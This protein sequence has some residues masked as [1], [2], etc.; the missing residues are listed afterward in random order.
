MATGHSRRHTASDI[1]SELRH[2]DSGHGQLRPSRRGLGPHAAGAGTR[3]RRARHRGGPFHHRGRF[4]RGPRLRP[5]TA[6]R[7]SRPCSTPRPCTSRMSPPTTARISSTPTSPAR[8]TCSRKRSRPACAR[9]SSPARPASSAR[10]WCRRLA[11]PPLGSPKTSAGPEEHLRRHQGGGRGSL[12][13]VPS[14]PAASPASCSGRRAS[15][16]RRTTTG[17]REAYADDNVKANEYL[18]RRVDIEDVVGAHLLAARLA[19]SLGFRRYIISATTPFSPA[20]L[21]ELTPRCGTRL[22]RCVPEYEA[23]YAA[24]AGRCCRP[25]TASMSTRGRGANSAGG[26]ATIS[27]L[28]ERLR[29]QGCQKPARPPRRRQGLSREDISPKVLILW[30]ER[31]FADDDIRVPNVPRRGSADEELERSEVWQDA[32]W[33]LTVSLSSEVAG[34]AYLEPKRHIRYITE[35]DGPEAAS[36]GPALGAQHKCPQG[37]CGRGGGLCLHLR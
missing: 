11:R 17:V 35:L 29:R 34:F 24:A 15:S 31:S 14:Q 6:W 21:A 28:I 37:R 9:S 12:P 23:E 25:S 1:A 7:A 22:R 26:P 27:L 3:G 32:H 20:D 36:F 2:E 5:R 8:S 18:Y 19:P 10:R 30:S 13:A 4:D 33:R 16:P